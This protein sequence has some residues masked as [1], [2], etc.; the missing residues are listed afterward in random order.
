[1]RHYAAMSD[2]AANPNFRRRWS[3]PPHVDDFKSIGE[4]AATV[5]DEMA[6]RAARHWLEQADHAEGE[7]R[8]TCLETADAI[9]RMAG[10]RWVDLFP[11][12]AA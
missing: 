3:E 12:V 5:A 10:L 9:L 8:T 6:H 2:P 7:E 1:M 4:V 11:R